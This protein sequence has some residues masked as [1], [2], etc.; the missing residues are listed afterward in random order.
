MLRIQ[1]IGLALVAV[2][3]MSSVAA[4]GASAH[5][6]L[7]NKKPITTATKIHS[8]GLLLLFDHNPPAGEV[9]VHCKGFDAGTVGPGAVDLIQSI[10]A[11]L[12]GTNDLIPCTIDKAGGCKSGTTAKALA[13]N[14]P[15]HT[16]L[17]EEG[18]EVRDMVTA[19]GAGEPG[20]DVTCENILGGKTTDACN[21]PL[22]STGKL[23][24]LVGGLGVSTEFDAKSQAANCKVGTEALRTGAGLVRGLIKL[25]SP[26]A[27]EP[28]TF[29]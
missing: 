19:D 6:W 18:G 28:L 5:E 23:I 22:G 10:T 7:L 14:L 25:E 3:A 1:M 21:A 16:E 17:Y 11:E 27:T 29:D 4:A 9:I 20:W 8:L 2:L 12:L 13:L 24:N 26:S 15:W